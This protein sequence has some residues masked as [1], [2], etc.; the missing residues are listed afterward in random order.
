MEPMGPPRNAPGGLARLQVVRSA[1][2]RT[3]ERDNCHSGKEW[4]Q[5]AAQP[6]RYC[7]SAKLLQ[8]LYFTKVFAG[9]KPWPQSSNLAGG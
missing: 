1:E 9:A 2:H 8:N 4:C 7:H 6:D 3:F 5:A